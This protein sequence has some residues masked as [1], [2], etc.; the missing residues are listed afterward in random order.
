MS[1]TKRLQPHSGKPSV[2]LTISSDPNSQG[3]LSQDVIIARYLEGFAV[4]KSKNKK[5]HSSSEHLR[6]PYKAHL[7]HDLSSDIA[8][9]RPSS[10]KLVSNRPA[11]GRSFA[12]KSSKNLVPHPPKRKRPTSAPV[13]KLGTGS[14]TAFDDLNGSYSASMMSSCSFRSNTKAVYRKKQHILCVQA[15]INGSRERTARVTAADLSQLL[16][17]CT[18]KLGLASAGRKLFLG[19]GTLVVHPKQLR[20]DCE[21][22]ISMGEP[23]RDP[24]L[25][26]Q[27]RE[28]L[29]KASFW[30]MSGIM[31]PVNNKKPKRLSSSI[32]NRMMELVDSQKRR[33]LVFKNGESFGGVEIIANRFDQFL[34]DCTTKLGLSSGARTLYDWSGKSVEMFSQVPCLDKVLQPSSGTVLGPLW[35]TKGESFS[36]TGAYSFLFTMITNTKDRIKSSEEYVQQLEDQLNGDELHIFYSKL[37]IETELSEENQVIDELQEALP[38]LHGYLKKIKK[39]HDKEEAMSSSSY[40]FKHITE[41]DSHSRLVGTSG[42]RLKLY[43]NGTPLNATVPV[44]LFFNTKDL[45]KGTKTRAEVMERFFDVLNSNEEVMRLFGVLSKRSFVRKAYLLNGTEVTDFDTLDHG[46]EVWL[47]LGESFLPIE[48]PVLTIMLEKIKVV[49]LW[50]LKEITQKDMWLGGDQNQTK[51]KLW[52]IC[53][54]LPS[55]CEMQEMKIEMTNKEKLAYFKQCSETCITDAATYLQSKENHSLVMYPELSFITKGHENEGDI[56]GSFLQQWYI[57]KDGLILNK[58]F[59][60]LVLGILDQS[61][62]MT[63]SNDGE[64]ELLDGAVVSCQAKPEKDNYNCVWMFTTDGYIQSIVNPGYVLTAVSGFSLNKLKTDENNHGKSDQQ[65][66]ITNNQRNGVVVTEHYSFSDENSGDENDDDNDKVNKEKNKKDENETKDQEEESVRMNQEMEEDKKLFENVENVYGGQNISL[67]VMPRFPEKHML[68]STQKWALKTLNPVHSNISEKWSRQNLFWPVDQ[69]N[70]FVEEVVEGFL[71]YGAPKLKWKVTKNS[72]EEIFK[73]AKTDAPAKLMVLRNGET[74]VSRALK[75]I[76]PDIKSLKKDIRV[77][78]TS[79]KSVEGTVRLTPSDIELYQFL[80]RCTEALNLP[81]AARR[82]FTSDGKEVK[83]LGSLEKN[84]LVYVSCGENWNN[85]SVSYAENQKRLLLASLAADVAKIRNYVDLKKQAGFVVKVDGDVLSD[86]KKLC[87]MDHPY[88]ELTEIENTEEQVNEIFEAESKGNDVFRD[89]ES[90]DNHLTAHQRSHLKQNE[91]SLNLSHS[92][93]EL[94]S[95]ISHRDALFGPDTA[96]QEQFSYKWVYSDEFIYLQSN[97]NLV[98]GVQGNE[99][100][101]YDY[102]LTCRK[103]YEDANQRWLLCTDGTICL[104]ANPNRVLAVS[105][106]FRKTDEN[107]V[108]RSYYGAKLMLSVKKR[109]MNGNSNQ[110]FYF[111]QATGYIHAFATDDVNMDLTSA[112][113]AGICTYSV[114][115]ETQVYQPGFCWKQQTEDGKTS[116]LYF[117]DACGKNIRGKQK[118]ETL[119]EFIEFSC[120]MGEARKHKLKMVGA[121][122]CLNGKVDLSSLECEST[123]AV[124]EMQLHRLRHESSIRVIASE[125]TLTQSNP[126]VRVLAHRNGDS[127]SEGVLVIGNMISQILDMCTVKLN[128]SKAARRLYTMDGELITNM[129]QLLKPYYPELTY[130]NETFQDKS[131]EHGEDIDDITGEKMIIE[132]LDVRIPV[133]VWVSLGENFTPLDEVEKADILA[134]YERS[135]KTD[136]AN[137][138][139]L[140]KHRLRQAKGRRLSGRNSQL[141]VKP[142]LSKAW[143]SPSAAEDKMEESIT[144]FKVQLKEVKSQQESRAKELKVRKSSTSKLLDKMKTMKLYQLPQALKLHVFPNGENPERSEVIFARHF[145]ELLDNAS[146]KLSLSNCARRAFTV[147]GVEILTMENLQRGQSVCITSGERFVPYKDRRNHMELKASWSRANRQGNIDKN[148][149]LLIGYKETQDSAPMRSPMLALPSPGPSSYQDTIV[150]S[151]DERTSLSNSFNNSSQNTVLSKR[152]K[153]AR[154]TVAHPR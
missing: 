95:S 106:P 66:D 17:E 16:A 129:Q 133:D 36:P 82:L 46:K 99:N 49:N 21:V 50:G 130:I 10:A 109:M 128:L 84:E 63:L 85:P 118:L 18:S 68:A 152:P 6:S 35:V 149:N 91:L 137:H 92:D 1:T 9:S 120:A 102:L 101:N 122:Q 59:K 87:L 107:A 140:E 131:I 113:K 4:G 71:T 117:C 125:M 38:K 111:D 103:K 40:K 62:Q 51:A 93:T 57:T 154:V 13:Y 88:D 110:L 112:N 54:S 147:H 39:L 114:F 45:K 89:K 80:E 77:A 3:I 146:S 27:E 31:M 73:A 74:D 61:V 11:S 100:N 37:E 69:T 5:R 64:E 150:H 43:A 153:S 148:N 143:T 48:Y 26:L 136:A 145:Q 151:F 123:L 144:K 76:G 60:G 78:F 97:P 2:N 58:H 32:S 139:E 14:W 7:Q 67:V 86:G 142:V 105:T 25:S 104:K 141:H 28:K 115:N 124:W 98:I 24:Y 96:V 47:S 94:R 70:T 41:I 55:Q 44:K 52:N 119:N 121:F 108:E 56:W 138:L 65:W 20:K 72:E 29:R 75:I 90:E 33:V 127:K 12:R 81:F 135:E 132:K 34:Q 19:D 53:S 8:L 79:S 42:I 126:A 23:F 22:Y 83:S 15:F 134:K 116:K 30:T